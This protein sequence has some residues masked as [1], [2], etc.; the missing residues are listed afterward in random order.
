MPVMIGRKL[1][2]LECYWLSAYS[3]ALPYLHWVRCR[4]IVLGNELSLM[5][6]SQQLALN[7][8]IR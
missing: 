7:P 2:Y 8:K 5:L 4:Q 6:A 1:P 3:R